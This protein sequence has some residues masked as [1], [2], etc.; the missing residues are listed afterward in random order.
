MEAKQLIDVLKGLDPKNDEHWT[1][2]GLPR[3][4]AVGP[5]VTRAQV[6]AVAPLFTRTEPRIEPVPTVDEVPP[7][8][9]KPPVEPDLISTEFGDD[10]ED[11]VDRV[12]DAGLV[13]RIDP[14]EA[15]RNLEA[16]QEELAYRRKKLEEANLE[17]EQAT[18]VVDQAIREA[19][20]AVAGQA[21]IMQ[22]LSSVTKAPKPG[23]ALPGAAPP[24]APID[25]A[26]ERK[27]GY[28]HQRPKFT[29]RQ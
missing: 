18:K 17:L 27:Q 12:A 15:Q 22:F 14:E 6:V 19:P 21:V 5:D 11:Q 25:K 2:D 28:G 10:D 8:P 20:P 26:F 3:L 24:K 16:A 7:T 9:P 23:P 1:A 4:A 13:Q 29:P